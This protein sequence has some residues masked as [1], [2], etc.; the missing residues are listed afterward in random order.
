MNYKRFGIVLFLVICIIGFTINSSTAEQKIT[1][2]AYGQIQGNIDKSITANED[3]PGVKS[4]YKNGVF[5][6]ASNGTPC[7]TYVKFTL[8]DKTIVTYNVTVEPDKFYNLDPD[9]KINDKFSLNIKQVIYGPNL[10]GTINGKKYEIVSN[11]TYEIVS[12]GTYGISYVKYQL[13]DNTWHYITVLVIECPGH[14]FIDSNGGQVVTYRISGPGWKIRKDVAAGDGHTITIP[15]EMNFQTLKIHSE[16]EHYGW[17]FMWYDNVY[18]DIPNYDGTFISTYTN[19][20]GKSVAVTYQG[21]T[22]TF[23]QGDH[24]SW[25]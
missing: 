8:V 12:N 13:S 9:G 19:Y 20:G 16:T 1:I 24:N 7:E 15:T 21:T 3:G 23:Y 2:K 17:Y 5:H 11:G 25:D 10:T 14:I 4:W 18:I 22:R 6:I